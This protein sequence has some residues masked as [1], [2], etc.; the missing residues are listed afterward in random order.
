MGKTTDQP[1]GPA[2]PAATDEPEIIRVQGTPEQ[3]EKNGAALEWFNWWRAQ[4]PVEGEISWEEFEKV[5]QE[6]AMSPRN[7]G[8]E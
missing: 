6:N 3:R 8:H 1:A 4:P 5:M 2:G 7:R